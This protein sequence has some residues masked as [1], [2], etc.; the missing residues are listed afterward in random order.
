VI[1]TS[2][3]IQS[4]TSLQATPARAP[5]RLFEYRAYSIGSDGH[6]IECAEMICRDDGEAIAKAKGLLGA[7]DIEVW[8]HS[9]FVIRLVHTPK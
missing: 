9:R 6:F 3:K 7:S 5:R 1:D 4:S 2:P 8:N